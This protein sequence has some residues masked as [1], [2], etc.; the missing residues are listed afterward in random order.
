MNSNHESQ[1]EANWHCSFR[2]CRL[3]MR[4]LL[5]V[6]A[7]FLSI[8]I[9]AGGGL[10]LTRSKSRSDYEMFT[11]RTERSLLHATGRVTRASNHIP[12]LEIQFDDG[13]FALATFVTYP[14]Y[15][16][17]APKVFNTGPF[18][19]SLLSRLTKCKTVDLELLRNSD[20]VTDYWIYAITCDGVSLLAFADTVA[21][22]N[23]QG[24]R[25]VP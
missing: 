18:D 8:G 17:R 25:F 10:W 23:G 12:H 7:L 16:G 14:I 22:L 5:S 13:H 20:N 4:R 24:R 1:S 6:A 19:S 9:G 21:Y 11:K 2:P 3:P 15:R